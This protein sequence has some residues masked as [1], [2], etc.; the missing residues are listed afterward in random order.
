MPPPVEDTQE[1]GGSKRKAIVLLILIVT[2]AFF[3][4]PLLEEHSGRSHF[5]S[6]SLN[7]DSDGEELDNCP[8][9]TA[10]LRTA[11]G[12]RDTEIHGFPSTGG[13]YLLEV[14]GPVELDFLG[15]DRFRDALPSDDPVKEDAF[16]QRMRAMGAQW[17]ENETEAIR[18]TR[19]E[20]KDGKRIGKMELWLGWPD[21]GGGVWVLEVEEFDGMR[22]GVGGR[23]RNAK[24]MKERCMVIEML[25][26]TFF[27]DRK[28]CALTSDIDF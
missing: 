18:P 9:T 26:G 2:T 8:V 16:C 10:K 25:G 15:L 23:I 7:M 13:L 1:T 28:D 24:D 12:G 3:L 20:Y 17:F 6:K 19:L 5:K 14:A 22:R 27:G 11:F 21:D 4:W